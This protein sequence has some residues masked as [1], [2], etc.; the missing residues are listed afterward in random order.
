VERT[1]PECI[2][3]QLMDYTLREARSTGH[4]QF[5]RKEQHSQQRDEMDHNVQTLMFM[6]MTNEKVNNTKIKLH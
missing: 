2:P 6:M 4:P 1:E 5:H 3:K